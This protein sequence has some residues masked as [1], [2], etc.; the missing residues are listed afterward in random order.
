MD[1][2][3]LNWINEINDPPMKG[4]MGIVDSRDER[5][6]TLRTPSAEVANSFDLSYPERSLSLGARFGN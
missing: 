4:R 2:A 1:S 6:Q 3:E 5:P